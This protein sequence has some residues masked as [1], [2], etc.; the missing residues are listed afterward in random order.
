MPLTR[1]RRPAAKK[2]NRAQ[3]GPQRTNSKKPVAKPG[4]ARAQFDRYTA[5]AQEAARTGDKIQAEN[6]YQHAEHYLRL[7]NAGAAPA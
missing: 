6:F 1:S 5:L 3:A 2:P 7:L 4:N